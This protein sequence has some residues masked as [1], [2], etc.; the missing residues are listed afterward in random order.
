MPPPVVGTVPPLSSQGTPTP[1][2]GPTAAPR[3]PPPWGLPD[4]DFQ[5]GSPGLAPQLSVWPVS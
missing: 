1:E 4:S 5:Q 3:D 2:T